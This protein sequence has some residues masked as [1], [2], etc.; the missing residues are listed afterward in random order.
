MAQLVARMHGVHEVGSSS[1]PGPISIL[2]RPRI[3][4]NQKPRRKKTN[5]ALCLT[6]FKFYPDAVMI[7]EVSAY[8]LPIIAG[9]NYRSF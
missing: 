6:K 1:L 5:A 2:K 4:E 8:L 7:R 9:N 3:I